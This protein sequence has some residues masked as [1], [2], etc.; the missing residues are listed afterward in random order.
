MISLDFI[1]RPHD[2]ITFLIR[3]K[4]NN[5]LH[6]TIYWNACTFVSLFLCRPTNYPKAESLMKKIILIALVLFTLTSCSNN[7]NDRI[8]SAESPEVESD[9][10]QDTVYYGD[11]QMGPDDF[12]N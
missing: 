3:L 1:C 2:I 4:L 10:N 6:Y 12:N 11:Y 5:R 8:K 7:P 9:E